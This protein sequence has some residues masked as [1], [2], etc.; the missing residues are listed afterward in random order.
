MSLNGIDKW[1]Q[2]PDS[3]VLGTRLLLTADILTIQAQLP[4]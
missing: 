1:T 2:L 4:I 3:Q